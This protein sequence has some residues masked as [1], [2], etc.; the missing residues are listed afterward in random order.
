M[1]PYRPPQYEGPPSVL[2]VPRGKRLPCVCLKCASTDKEHIRFQSRE[3]RQPNTGAAV[4]RGGLRATVELPLCERCSGRIPG[5]GSTRG[6]PLYGLLGSLPLAFVGWLNED[7]TLVVLGGSVFVG[8]VAVTLAA[9]LNQRQF[10]CQ[11]VEDDGV[12]I[13][14]VAPAALTAIRERS[15]D[16]KKKKPPKEAAAY[17]TDAGPFESA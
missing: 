15:S 12:T 10:T 16:K 6:L 3:F 4:A 2:F 11:R 14:G 9:K 5:V 1:D 8:A 7:I 13:G 17:Q